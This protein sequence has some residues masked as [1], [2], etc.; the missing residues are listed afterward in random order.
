MKN[1]KLLAIILLSFCFVSG[2]GY[3]EELTLE[4]WRE[5]LHNQKA[6]ELD[7][8]ILK[9]RTSYIMENPTNFL[10]IY[11]IYDA[12]GLAGLDDLRE[13]KLAF[14]GIISTKGKLVVWIRDNRAAFSDKSRVDLLTIFHKH[15]LA[16]LYTSA[17]LGTFFPYDTHVLAI[18]Y[19]EEKVPVGYFYE[20][21]YHLWEE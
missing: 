11:C 10:N 17:G 3:G 15:L 21:E 12:F 8:T 13:K 5:G 6:S 7:L 2:V 16:F 19:T 18:F 1:K 14:Y 20:G 4:E 9:A